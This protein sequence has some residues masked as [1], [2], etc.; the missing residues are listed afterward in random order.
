MKASKEELFYNRYSDE[1]ENRIN[2]LETS[3]RLKVVYGK[4]LKGI[5]L[6]GQ[7]FL[8]VGCGLGYFS[9]KA[10]NLGAN[11][12]G[13]D[14]GKKLVEKSK[15]RIPMGKFIVASASKLPFNNGRFDVVL[16]TEVIEHVENYQKALSEMVRVLKKGGYLVITTPNKVFRPLFLFLNLTGLRPYRGNENWL[17]PWQLKRRLLKY[18]KVKKEYP[19]N[20]FYPNAFIDFFERYPILGLM[21]INQGYLIVKN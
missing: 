4:L 5:N 11:V 2:N 1:W 20:F 12:Y 15:S 16:C 18:G 6:K 14:I 7:Q 9:E 19:F 21:M 10:V 3:K 13:V 8:D 17:Y